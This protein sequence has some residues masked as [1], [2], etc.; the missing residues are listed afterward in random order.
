MLAFPENK[1]LSVS[2]HETSNNLP[3]SLPWIQTVKC[4]DKHYKVQYIRGKLIYP[5]KKHKMTELD[6]HL[7]VTPDPKWLCQTVKLDVYSL[8]NCKD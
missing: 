2:R 1:C 3:W 4:K 7:I 6:H 5:L 8:Q